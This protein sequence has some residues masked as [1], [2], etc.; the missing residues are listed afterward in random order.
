MRT[1]RKNVR[2]VFASYMFQ[3]RL[4]SVVLCD[5]YVRTGHPRK[6]HSAN[7]VCRLSD[8]FGSETAPVEITVVL[9]YYRFLFAFF[10][11]L[12]SVSTLF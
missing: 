11:F 10:L 4:Q 7:T 3:T 12:V 1:P 9:S 8:C 2:S 5:Q 6:K